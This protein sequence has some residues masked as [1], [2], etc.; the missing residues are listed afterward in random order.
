MGSSEN[1]SGGGVFLTL[2]P[3]LADASVK[4]AIFLSAPL[5]KGKNVKKYIAMD[6]S[7]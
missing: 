7:L 5:K 6:N 1:L 2:Y 3:P 4:N